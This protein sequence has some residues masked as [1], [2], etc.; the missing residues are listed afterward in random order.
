MATAGPIQDSFE[1]YLCLVQQDVVQKVDAMK[2][3]LEKY[4]QQF[5]D[6][7]KLIRRQ[8][9]NV[10]ASTCTNATTQSL[11]NSLTN[12][13]SNN[14]KLQQQQQFQQQQ[15]QQ[16]QHHQGGGNDIGA[17]LN[18]NLN[19]LAVL[20]SN[21]LNLNHAT[22]TYQ[23]HTSI[24]SINQ[25]NSNGFINN[26][27][28]TNNQ[29]QHLV[30]NQQQKAILNNNYKQQQ[31][32]QQSNNNNSSSSNSNDTCAAA[33]SLDALQNT[34]NFSAS[35]S[36]QANE[37]DLED[38]ESSDINSSDTTTTTTTTKPCHPQQIQ[39]SSTPNTPHNNNN[40]NNV[41][42]HLNKEQ[43]QFNK[44]VR[45]Q[46][47]KKF[48]QDFLLQHEV[49]QLEASIMDMIKSEA[50]ASYL[51]K[52]TLATRAWTLAKVSLRSLKR[53]LRRKQ[54]LTSTVTG[55]SGS[56]K[57]NSSFSSSSNVNN[58]NNATKMNI[59]SYYDS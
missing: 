28:N 32:Q 23:L 57:K 13:S 43:A 17:H 4:A 12:E 7:I 54:G 10:A 33:A 27:N 56:L 5:I 59:D 48:G 40:N 3:N 52:D 45:D 53:D 58:T 24:N 18:S 25:L 19:V 41:K 29:H 31:Q 15:F 38:F 42:R 55:G 21:N 34:F 37:E 26:N 36:W 51:P 14:N 6:N 46:V 20:N 1:Q 22:T 39:E 47:S 2:T 8:V 30:Q 16:Q 44:F 11:I 35:S 50:L 9:Q 49:N